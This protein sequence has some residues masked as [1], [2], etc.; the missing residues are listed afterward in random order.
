MRH[1]MFELLSRAVLA[2]NNFDHEKDNIYAVSVR[3]GHPDE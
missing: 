1:I 2:R 3:S